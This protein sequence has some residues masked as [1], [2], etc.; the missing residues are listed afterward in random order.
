[1][2]QANGITKRR[3]WKQLTEKE[4]YKIE[5]LSQVGVSPEVI[6]V[7]LNRDRRTIERELKRGMTTQ[8]D[9]QWRERRV[10]LADV[11]QRVHDKNASNKGRGLK[12]GNDHKLAMYL[13]QKIAEEKWSPDAVIGSINQQ[14]LKFATSLCT[15][16]VYNMIARGDFLN[17]TNK[18]LP[19]KK[20][21][22]KR[23]YKPVRRVALNNLKGRNIEERPEAVNRREEYGHWEM[24][25]VVGSTKACLLVLTERKHREEIIIKLA[26]KTQACV[27]AAINALERKHGKGFTLKFKSFT[28][29]NGCEFLDSQGIENSCLRPGTKRTICYYAHPYCAWERGSNENQNRLIRRFIPKGSNIGKLS[30]SDIL[31]VQ[32][33]LNNYPRKILHYKSPNLLSSNL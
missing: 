33:W 18:H 20:D 21:A 1:M 15:K 28:M 30:K 17:L 11:G 27:I 24:D 4:R 8:V 9:S 22:K 29:D 25:S 26:A 13:E 3:Q 14:G 32:L 6:A 31:R 5:A 16:T 23:G 2:G 10:Y 7:Q 12:I 19:N